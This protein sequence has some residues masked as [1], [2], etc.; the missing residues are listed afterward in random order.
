MRLRGFCGQRGARGGRGGWGRGRAY[1][2]G[3]HVAV[4]VDG[5]LAA[6][7][8]DVEEAGELRS[9]VRV[10]LG[11]AGPDRREEDGFDDAG[12]GSVVEGGVAVEHGGWM[13]RWIIGWTGLDVE[14]WGGV[15]G[16]WWWEEDWKDGGGW[17]GGVVEGWGGVGGG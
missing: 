8:V 15:G 1:E 13:G 4:V 6:Y 2:G 9:V 16:C 3:R 14:G 12:E 11:V 5:R 10:A 7:F 17:R